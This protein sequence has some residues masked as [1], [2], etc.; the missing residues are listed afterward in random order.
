MGQAEQLQAREGPDAQEANVDLSPM[1]QP[2][3]AS[4][5]AAEGRR[6]LLGRS[7]GCGHS[8]EDSQRDLINGVATACANPQ[9]GLAEHGALTCNG[10]LTIKEAIQQDTVLRL[11]DGKTGSAR[12]PMDQ[13]PVTSSAAEAHQRGG[14]GPPIRRVR[15]K[16][17]VAPADPNKLYATQLERFLSLLVQAD[18]RL[19]GSSVGHRIQLVDC[20]MTVEGQELDSLTEE[21]YRRLTAILCQS[22]P[23]EDMFQSLEAFAHKKK[24]LPLR[25]VHDEQRLAYWLNTQCARLRAGLLLEH[26]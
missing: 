23:W 4:D 12:S 5:G 20:R 22:D 9:Q 25:R 2:L 19:V 13:Q 1:P 11:R 18:S 14:T 3:S 21:V 26:R 15:L 16:S 8:S 7:G 6:I 24:R 17:Y 10:H